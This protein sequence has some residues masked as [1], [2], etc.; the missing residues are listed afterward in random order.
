MNDRVIF[1]PSR[2]R[3]TLYT[4]LYPF[5]GLLIA[6]LIIGDFDLNDIYLFLFAYLF[7]FLILC[8]PIYTLPVSNIEISSSEITGPNERKRRPKTT[9]IKFSDIVLNKKQ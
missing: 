1:I 3:Y 7:L 6:R 8:L 2:I 9:T 5:I 4:M